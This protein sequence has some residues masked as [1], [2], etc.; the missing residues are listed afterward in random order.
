VN[1]NDFEMKRIS[2]IISPSLLA[3]GADNFASAIACVEQAGAE[4]LHIDVM[5]G[6]FV[7]NL[8]FGPN[9]VAGIRAC[10]RMFFDVHLMIE[11][12]V[13]FTGPFIDAGA[14]G[15]TIHPEAGDNIDAVL[16]LC[17]ERGV[18]FGLALKPETTLESVERYLPECDILLIMGIQPG[19]GGQKFM[20]SALERIRVAKELR[21]KINA[22]Y[23]IGVDGGVNIEKGTQCVAAGADILVAG[24]AIFGHDN[25]A[26][27]IVALKGEK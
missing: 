5:D 12:P 7:P 21:T 2:T 13:K 14:D 20:P 25:P 24:S 19:F 4:Y 16:S 22:H 17:R 9:I 23:K 8:S 27:V 15:I 11:D 26:A 10:T 3:A 6:N 18:N 1:S